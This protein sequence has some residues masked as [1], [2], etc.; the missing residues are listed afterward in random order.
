MSVQSTIPV[1]I[2]HGPPELGGLAI[3]DLRT[4]A[5]LEAVK[6]FRNSIYAD[7]EN[8]NLLR[9]NLQF[10]QLESGVGN[11]LLERPE[12]QIPYLTPTWLLSMR[13][14]L[15][16]HN[17]T[18]TVSDAYSIPLHS[19]SDQYIMQQCHPLARYTVSQQRDINLVRIYLQINT[20]ADMTDSD[21]PKSIRLDY[22]DHAI[23]P[24]GVISAHPWPRQQ[25]LQ[26]PNDGFGKD[27]SDR[28]IYAMCLTGSKFQS[29]RHILLLRPHRPSLPCRSPVLPPTFHPCPSLI[30]GYWRILNKWV[31]TSR[32]GEPFVQNLTSSLPPTVVYTNTKVLTGGSSPLAKRS[33]L[34]AQVQ[35]TAHS[36]RICQQDMNSVG[37]HRA[38]Y[39]WCPSPATGV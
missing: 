27:I 30:A 35:L 10:L 31:W 15:F 6:V 14:F 22:L 4:E 16:C 2:Q 39:Y 25:P 28:P 19:N 13:Q 24:E 11:P 36:T 5:G 34:S 18:I 29:L 20:L 17:M 1:A 7:S 32:Y 26:S 12:L 3:Y 33:C 9:L 38:C 23:C 37:A 8:G 21:H